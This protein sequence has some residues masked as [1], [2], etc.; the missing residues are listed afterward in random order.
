MALEQTKKKKKLKPLEFSLTYS[1][2]TNIKSYVTVAVTVLG[3]DDL[4]LIWNCEGAVF[5]SSK[6]SIWP[7]QCQVLEL[8]PEV[9]KKHILMSALWFGPRKQSM[10]TLLK[11][12]VKEASLLE[13]EGVDWQD[14]QG[15]CHVSKV[16]VLV[17]SSDSV[18]R[19]LIHN[20]KQFNGFYGCDFCYHK[21][22]KSYPYDQPEPPLRN[23]QDHF[24]LAMSAS[25]NEPV[26]G[27]KGPSPLI[28][29][30][31]FQ[32]INGFIHE[33]QHSVCLGVTRQLSTL[34]FDSSNGEATWYIG[35]QIEEVDVRLK[36]FKPPVEITRTQRPMSESKFWKASEW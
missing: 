20:T 9:R 35:K 14:V 6:F 17:C 18:T 12:F 1:L 21:G 10:L 26:F 24:E 15:N 13:T 36:K 33:Y 8:K 5:K 19:P 29:L 28:K 16:F 4:T 3:E 11:S 34:W 31:D 30:S 22:G 2:E 32:M 23:D 27:V 25:E 7:I